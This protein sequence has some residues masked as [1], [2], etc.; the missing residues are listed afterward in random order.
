MHLERV[1]PKFVPM[2]IKKDPVRPHISANDR[3]APGREMYHIDELAF[4]CLAFTDRIP[5]SEVELLSSNV[6]DIAVA[7]TVWSLKRGLGRKIIFETQKRIQD[8]F[9][10]S[11][12][13]TF[14]P[15]TEMAMKFHLSNGATLLHELEHAYNFEYNIEH[16]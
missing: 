15:K 6:G 7:Y 3:I 8:T 12:L 9:R 2:Y 13:V 16:F 1:D 10:F 11:R 4:I 14:S 5:V